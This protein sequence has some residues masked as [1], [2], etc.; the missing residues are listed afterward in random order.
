LKLADE[1]VDKRYKANGLTNIRVF[2]AL[3]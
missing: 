3:V 2:C 1:A